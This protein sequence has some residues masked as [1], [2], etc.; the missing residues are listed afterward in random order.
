MAPVAQDCLRRLTCLVNFW[1]L[2]KALCLATP[3]LCGASIT[4][5][6]KKKGRAYPIAVCETIR[7]LV[8]RVFCLSVRDNLPDLFLPY[9]YGQVGV[10]IKSSLE[11]AIHSFRSYLQNDL[12]AVKLDMCNA[13]NEV[14]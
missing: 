7:C 14:Q 8:S 12:C 5:L 2:G 9:V 4:A 6:H 13:F 11:A 3:W 1:L 10:G